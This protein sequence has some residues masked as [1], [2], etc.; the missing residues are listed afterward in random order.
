MRIVIDVDLNANGDVVAEHV[1]HTDTD[2]WNL[3]QHPDGKSGL[4]PASETIDHI[5][6]NVKPEDHGWNIISKHPRYRG[7][8]R[9]QVMKAEIA[10]LQGKQN[11]PTPRASLVIEEDK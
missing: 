8:T 2:S 7:M 6:A 9:L 1:I 3:V 10:R 11:D 5:V 4:V